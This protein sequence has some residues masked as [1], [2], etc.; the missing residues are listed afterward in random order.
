MCAGHGFNDLIQPSHFYRE[1][2]V[3]YLHVEMQKPVYGRLRAETS[4]GDRG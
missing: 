3:I 1:G 4:G 2:G